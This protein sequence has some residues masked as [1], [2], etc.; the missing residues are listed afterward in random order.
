MGGCGVE[1]LWPHSSRDQDHYTKQ[2]T[3]GDTGCEGVVVL[4]PQVLNLLRYV[5]AEIQEF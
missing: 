5:L 3:E 4:C 1:S 2:E